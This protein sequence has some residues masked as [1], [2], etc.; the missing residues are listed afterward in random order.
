MEIYVTDDTI[1]RYFRRYQLGFRFVAHGA[2]TQTTCAWSGLTRDQLVTLRRRWGFDP[3]ERR[4]GP[5]PTA[6]H[7]FF[8]SKRHRS[9]AALFACLCRIVGA[10]TARRGADAAK[11]LPGLE[12]G[13]LLCEALEAYREWQPE[14]AL[15]F[16]HA[17]LLVDGVVQATAV[18]L[19]HCSHCH[20]AML[21]DRMGAQHTTC[22]HCARLARQNA[23]DAVIDDHERAEP[24][25]Q[26]DH[27]P[28]REGRSGSGE[29]EGDR[30]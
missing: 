2:R 23:D 10:T 18:A 14:A 3:D 13:E 20:G 12:N 22:G 6:Y 9:E 1:G 24:E 28:E 15:E 17:V 26:S 29:L 4:R 11:R 25:R 30:D 16:E 21:V 19:A 8:R 27:A 5:A 7:V